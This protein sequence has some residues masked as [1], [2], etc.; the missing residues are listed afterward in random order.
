MLQI[1]RKS[2]IV[3]DLPAEL[4]TSEKCGSAGKRELCAGMA[5]F[6]HS[7]FALAMR[8]S[9]EADSQSIDGRKSHDDDGDDGVTMA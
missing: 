4:D 6:K 9:R 8:Q 5:G 7:G 2:A 1:A 3:K